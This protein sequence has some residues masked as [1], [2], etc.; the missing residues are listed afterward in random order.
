M[1]ATAVSPYSP[2][3]SDKH[4]RYLVTAEVT[5]SV[6]TLVAAS[7]REEACRIADE[8]SMGTIQDGECFG[9]TLDDVWLTSGEIDGPAKNLRAA[10]HPSESPDA[11]RGG[12]K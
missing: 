8:R 11:A 3:R 7:S 5:I 6:S 10:L 1:P 9:D 4:L 2:E 12:N